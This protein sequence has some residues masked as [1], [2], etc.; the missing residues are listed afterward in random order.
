MKLWDPEVTRKKFG[1]EL[2]ASQ[3]EEIH[4]RFW[5]LKPSE[6]WADGVFEGGGVLGT[7]FLGALRCCEDLGLRWM[8][9]A[10]TSAG[11]ITSA[12]L[13]AGYSID[14]IEDIFGCLDF[15]SFLRDPSDPVF[16]LNDPKNDLDPERLLESVGILS[17][18]G[19]LGKYSSAPFYNWLSGLLTP[20]GIIRFEDIREKGRQLKIIAADISRGQMIVLPDS[21]EQEPYAAAVEVDDANQTERATMAQTFEVAKA[22]RLSMSIPVVF[23]PETLGDSTIVDGGISSNFPLWLYDVPS[24]VQ[25]RYPTFGFRLGYDGT[26]KIE[27]AVGVALGLISTMRYGH[28]RFYLQEK[29]FGRVVHIDLSNVETTSTHFRL[30][31]DE[32][33]ELYRRGYDSTR[34]FFLNHWCW[35]EHLRLRGFKTD[36]NG[37]TS[38]LPPEE[39][40]SPPR[41]NTDL[42]SKSQ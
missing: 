4:R 11:A 16:L 36:P 25:P 23:E 1:L 3:I 39:V 18:V 32:K 7:A 41:W 27:S 35:K 14:A 2:T 8:N 24:G 9:L 21:L 12:L 26:N 30:T 42:R 38:L 28:D 37:K 15:N 17:I 22:V 20:R 10:G 40:E 29:D 5:P 34:Q 6:L 33:D 19:K 13:A 31:N